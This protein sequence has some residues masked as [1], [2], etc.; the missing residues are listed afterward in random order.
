[1][2]LQKL[3]LVGVLVAGG[4]GAARLTER[5]SMVA[6]LV[7]LTLYQWNPFVAERL[8][9]GHWPVLVGY[10]ALP[11]VVLSAQRW[12][13]SGHL[14][15]AIVVAAPGRQ[16]ERERRSGHGRRPGCLRR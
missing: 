11:W 14:P 1:M 15:A 8:L 10:A 2:L 3:I 9:I 12:R 7:A 6:G 4:I 16:P 13:D 5:R